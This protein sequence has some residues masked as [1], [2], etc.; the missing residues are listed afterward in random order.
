MNVRV[1]EFEPRDAA[2]VSDVI[3]TTMRVTNSAD[4]PPEILEPLIEYFSPEKVLQLAGERICLVAETEELIVGTIAL[5]G[6]ELQTFF[7]HPERQ[8]KGAG[9]RLLEAV[10]GIAARREIKTIHVMS[11]LS[12]ISFY[13]KMGYRKTGF[14]Q[15]KS[16]GRQIG[17][18]KTLEA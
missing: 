16:A 10:E 12:A 11:S 4:Y 13:E 9:K 8:G 1:R 3:R 15:E 18:E 2:D 7:V 14:E 6:S 5:Q 17:L